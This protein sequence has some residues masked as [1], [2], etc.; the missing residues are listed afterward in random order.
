MHSHTESA[1]I[2]LFVEKSSTNRER[3]TCQI[4]ISPSAAENLLRPP[5][6]NLPPASPLPHQDGFHTPAPEFSLFI[7]TL[8]F[9]AFDPAWYAAGSELAWVVSRQIPAIRVSPHR[10]PSGGTLSAVLLHASDN[11]ISRPRSRLRTSPRR[12]HP[13]SNNPTSAVDLGQIILRTLQLLYS[14][15]RLK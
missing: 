2:V 10:S 15:I 4:I 6:S 9:P 5:Q 1:A 12:A 8:L 13:S 7:F 14:I 11:F 3:Q